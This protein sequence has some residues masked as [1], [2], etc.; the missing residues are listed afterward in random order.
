[1][2]G[3]RAAR[4]PARGYGDGRSAQNELGAVRPPRPA[5]GREAARVQNELKPASNA[6]NE[7]TPASSVQNEQK[8]RARAKRTCVRPRSTRAA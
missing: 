3:W 6:Q 1:V 7:P 5:S 4:I 2:L 8:P